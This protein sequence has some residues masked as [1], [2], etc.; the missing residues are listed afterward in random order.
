MVHAPPLKRF[1]PREVV[2][3]IYC[4]SY[5][6][7]EFVLDRP[8]RRR[9]V[10]MKKKHKRVE[11]D[12]TTLIVCVFPGHWRTRF[13][14]TTD[15]IIPLC[16]FCWAIS[17]LYLLLQFSDVDCSTTTTIP[18]PATGCQTATAA[19]TKIRSVIKNKNKLPRTCFVSCSTIQRRLSRPCFSFSFSPS[20]LYVFPVHYPSNSPARRQCQW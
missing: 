5:P 3:G 20:S 10:H 14:T 8:S 15:A 4:A 9:T 16:S 1:A 17:C 6:L 19:G 12:A 18:P 2:E 13:M 11:P 7:L